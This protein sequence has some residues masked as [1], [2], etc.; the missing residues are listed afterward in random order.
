MNIQTKFDLGEQ[1]YIE[2]YVGKE[3]NHFL[4]EIKRIALHNST[5][6][7]EIRYTVEYLCETEWRQADRWEEDLERENKTGAAIQALFCEHKKW[8]TEHER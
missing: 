6:G 7:P 1:V 4:G 3:T 8:R 2:A 5:H